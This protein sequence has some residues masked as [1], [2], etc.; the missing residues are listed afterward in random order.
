[1]LRTL[2]RY[3]L[4]LLAGLLIAPLL[5]AAPAKTPDRT[6]EF[7]DATLLFQDKPCE[8][9]AVL[10]SVE[11]SERAKVKG[12]M[13]V[14]KY[15]GANPHKLCYVELEH[16]GQKYV[17]LVDEVGN[18][19]AIMLEDLIPAPTLPIPGNMAL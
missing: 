7:A 13:V 14:P 11:P 18:S 16:E 10:A 2:T 1:V 4:G 8:I 3:T 19:G 6:V 5:L 12:G 9:G 17:A 15:E